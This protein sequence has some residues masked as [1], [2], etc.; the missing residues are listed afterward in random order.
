MEGGCE[1]IEYALADSNVEKDL[2]EMKLEM[3]AEGSRYGRMGAL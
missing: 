2:W 1:Y 3:V